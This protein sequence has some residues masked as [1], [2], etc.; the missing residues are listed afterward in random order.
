[1]SNRQNTEKPFSSTEPLP[2]RLLD[3]GLCLEGIC[4][5][6]NGKCVAHKQMVIGTLEMGKFTIS[7]NYIF[8]CPM[9]ENN[10]R[11]NKFGLNRCQ[12][13]IIHT[14]KWLSVGDVYEKYDL[15][16][17]PINIETQPLPSDF[18]P[19]ENCSICLALMDKKNQ[20]FI[21]PCKHIFHM[22]CIHGW[23]DAEEDAS[24]Q[25]PIC[26]RPIFE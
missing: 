12:W 13:R 4:L 25:C 1:M 6:T 21:L 10:V 19:P 3:P 2:W 22:E 14:N 16:S 5:R 11:A 18:E 26:R 15:S 20:C 9:C 17:L 23:I 7:R 8:K 24:L